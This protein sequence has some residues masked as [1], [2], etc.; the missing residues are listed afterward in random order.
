MGDEGKN[1]LNVDSSAYKLDNERN[2]RCSKRLQLYALVG[3]GT[4]TRV[5]GDDRMTRVNQNGE[6][7]VDSY[8]E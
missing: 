5:I 2:L 1:K 6:N 4:K 7:L 3:N 8:K